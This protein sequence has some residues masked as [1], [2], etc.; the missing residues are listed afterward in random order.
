VYC[1]AFAPGHPQIS[2]SNIPKI[3]ITLANGEM[4]KYS[5][6][7]ESVRI[8][9]AADNT[10]VIDDPGLSSHHAVLHQR[11][12]GFEII[13]LGSTNGIEFEGARI[14]TRILQQGDKIQI[15]Q[16]TL[17]Y[18]APTAPGSGETE[19]PDGSPSTSPEDSETPIP[20]EPTDPADDVGETVLVGNSHTDEKPVLKKTRTIPRPEPVLDS[21]G[22][23]FLASAAL[24]FLTLFAPLIG[25]HIR[26]YQETGGVLISNV[27]AARKSPPAASPAPP[28][29]EDGGIA[30][31]PST[32]E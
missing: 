19:P 10:V 25:L 11:D 8:G 4:K 31:T 9:R 14:M 12:E 15:G 1:L 21:S 17:E 24:F 13:D 20:H 5:L 28:A 2:M 7:M 26:H 18:I 22:G 3:L 16:A 27:I 6:Q 30:P 32:E 23:G 29:D